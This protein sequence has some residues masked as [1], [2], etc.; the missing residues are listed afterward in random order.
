MRRYTV[1][2]AG[3]IFLVPVV[4]G[5]T[6]S[7]STT[8]YSDQ[9]CPT[10][11][12]KYKVDV[13]NPA[14][15][16]STVDLSVDAPWQ[17]DATLAP[18]QLTLDA[19]ASDTAYLWVQ[20]AADLTP[21]TYTFHVTAQD[22][23][24]GESTRVAETLDVLSCRAVDVSVAEPAQ[25]VC[26]NEAAT[27]T[28]TVQN[29]GA[30]EET[31]ELTASAGTLSTDSV[32]LG[33][34]KSTTVTVTRRSR[35]AVQEDITVTATSTASYAEDAE[36]LSFTADQCRSVDLFV[37]P[38]AQTVCS[39][40]RTELTA[41]VQNTGRL[42]DT[43]SVVTNTG[44]SKD[45]TLAPNA[46]RAVDITAAQGPGD[47]RVAVRA[48]SKSFDKVEAVRDASVTVE[49]C[50]GLDLDV[51]S[52]RTVALDQQN[53]SLLTYE[54]RNNGTRENTYTLALDGPSWMDVRPQRV[55]VPA[56]A[57]RAAYLYL[58]P[59][60]FSTGSYTATLSVSDTEQRVGQSVAVNVT[61][62]NKTATVTET[63]AVRGLTGQIFASP[64]TAVSLILAVVVLLALGIGYRTF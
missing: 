26:R 35:S 63:G 10:G 46:S 57:S 16:E 8:A 31:Y 27:Y 24:T 12:A 5:A 59:D 14:D 33:P 50:H 30:A 32:T 22:S 13:T 51:G 40:E 18:S 25:Q 45:I 64:A 55:T 41:T 23:A 38:S 17:D 53:T 4:S 20:A 2:L 54:V 42:E 56:G 44:Y 58:A 3:L 37:S 62:G 36:T 34:D 1:L 11:S 29:R 9:A 48:T 7:V 28:V 47:Q 6:P 43:Y 49:R 15:V 60:Y 61:V 19:G 39:D 21:G 52:T